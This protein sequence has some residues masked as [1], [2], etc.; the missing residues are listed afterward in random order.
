MSRV[1]L[2]R[3]LNKLRHAWVAAARYCYD[4]EWAVLRWHIPALIRNVPAQS[5]P[6]CSISVHMLL[7]HDTLTM[8]LWA[9]RSFQHF[10]QRCWKMVFHDDGSLEDADVALLQKHF[11]RGIVWRRAE[12]DL[13]VEAGLGRHP[14]CLR[15]RRDKI[16][17]L[18]LFDPFFACEGDRFIVLDSDVLFFQTP[19]EIL[20]WADATEPVFRFNP[21]TESGY[22]VPMEKLE[23]RY[24]FPI[25]K[26]VNAGLGLIPRAGISLDLIENYLQEFASESVNDLWLEQ[27][28]YALLASKFDRGGLLPFT[29]EISYRPARGG[30]CTARHYLSAGNSRPHFFREGVIT[31]SPL[32]LR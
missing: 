19:C 4:R 6:P 5:F 31:L 30:N 26:G 14:F 23:A 15:H 22:I 27:T 12:A 16:M 8:G 11:P 17:L 28:A 25:W 7:S 20:E 13:K 32:L 10:T 1:I 24:G 18:K 21:E 3:F 29:Y 9:A 2:Y